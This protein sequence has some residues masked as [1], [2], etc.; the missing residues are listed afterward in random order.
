MFWQLVSLSVPFKFA[1]STVP[2]VLSL[3][4]YTCFEIARGFGV[5]FIYGKMLSLSYIRSFVPPKRAVH[6]GR[7]S[8]SKYV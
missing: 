7:I 2:F 1:R 6:E 4:R 8:F 3:S 5:L